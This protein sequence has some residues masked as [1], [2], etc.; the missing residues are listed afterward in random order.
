M[1][2]LLQQ[3]L[4]LCLYALAA[5]SLAWSTYCAFQD[6]YEPAASSAASPRR[7]QARRLAIRCCSNARTSPPPNSLSL[8]SAVQHALGR[9]KRGCDAERFPK[10]RLRSMTA[11]HAALVAHQC[12]RLPPANPLEGS[13]SRTAYDCS[14]MLGICSA[15]TSSKS[16]KVR[17]TARL[18]ASEQL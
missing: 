16:V 1:D 12:E 10:R 15:S 7:S 9:C 2:G 4:A 6:A 5:C 3:T 18:R 8:A 14:T 13:V 11:R 17:V